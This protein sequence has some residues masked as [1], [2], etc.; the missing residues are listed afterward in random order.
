MEG[1]FLPPIS[2]TV[3][4]AVSLLIG[5]D[6]IEQQFDD[7]YRV[8]AQAARSKI[9]AILPSSVRNETSHVLRLCVC[10]SSDKTGYTFKRKEIS[11]KDPS[12]DI[13]RAKDKLSLCK[14]TADSEGI[15][16]VFVPL[17]P[18]DWCLFKDRGCS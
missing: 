4:E 9:E 8:R 17:L 16:I 6:F 5:T 12:S 15:T 2:F 7:D 18:M 10:S 1:Y 3:L 14:K 13:R 11:R